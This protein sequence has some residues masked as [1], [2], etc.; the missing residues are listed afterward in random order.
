MSINRES[1]S[2]GYA[3]PKHGTPDGVRRFLLTWS[4]NMSLLRSGSGRHLTVN[5][6]PGTPDVKPALLMHDAIYLVAA[7]LCALRL[8]GD[9]EIEVYRGDAEDAEVAQRVEN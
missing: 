8:G 5:C 9:V 1:E 3:A 7:A 4:I 6:R 2:L